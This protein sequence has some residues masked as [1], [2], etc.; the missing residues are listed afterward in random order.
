M[1]ATAPRL[2]SLAGVAYPDEQA[3][4]L[5]DEQAAAT[6]EAMERERAAL[7][8]K[9]AAARALGDQRDVLYWPGHPSGDWV[10]AGKT[11]NETAA[12]VEAQ[13]ASCVAQI[14][15]RRSQRASK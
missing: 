4:E 5:V 6:L 12:E 2:R 14:D 8:F 7:E 13:L 3:G 15:A 11:G 9:L 1:L 10:P